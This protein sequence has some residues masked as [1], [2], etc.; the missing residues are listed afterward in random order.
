MCGLM[1]AHF[2]RCHS[3]MLY[4]LILCEFQ[5]DNAQRDHSVWV[6]LEEAKTYIMFKYTGCK[7]L[8]KNMNSDV[9]HHRQEPTE[10]CKL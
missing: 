4:L 2:L 8:K 3:S 7:R 10:Q 6:V 1:S 5:F 9:I